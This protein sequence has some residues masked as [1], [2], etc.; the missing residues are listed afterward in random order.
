MTTTIELDAEPKAE[1]E[2]F[3]RVYGA[4]TGDARRVG[5]REAIGRH[6]V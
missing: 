3:E 2:G 6:I 1:S 5:V 4:V